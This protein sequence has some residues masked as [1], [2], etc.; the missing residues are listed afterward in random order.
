M[1]GQLEIEISISFMA[2]LFLNLSKGTADS[3]DL[4]QCCTEYWFIR[5]NIGIRE[6][7]RSKSI[8]FPIEINFMIVNLLDSIYAMFYTGNDG[9]HF[10]F[11]ASC[12]CIHFPGQRIG[13]FSELFIIVSYEGNGQYLSHCFL[14]IP[15]LLFIC[16]LL[17]W[18]YYFVFYSSHTWGRAKTAPR[19]FPFIGRALRQ[20]SP[21]R[22]SFLPRC[23]L[24]KL[25]LESVSFINN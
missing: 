11:S 17:L 3:Q 14:S 15:L 18:A 13:R 19:Q 20:E 10:E 23:G 21:L 12:P 22:F 2:G 5:A 24:E 16:G 6:H 9:C 25:A 1:R 8:N 4:V 7:D